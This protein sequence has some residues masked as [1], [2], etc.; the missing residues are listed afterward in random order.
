MAPIPL[1]TKRIVK[2]KTKHFVRFESED[3]A[4]MSSSWRK[5]RGIDNRVRR[6]F[7]GCRKVPKCG[8][9]SDKVI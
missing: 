3:F 8:F 1:L 4:K 9:G 5:N 6:R 7:A 2:K